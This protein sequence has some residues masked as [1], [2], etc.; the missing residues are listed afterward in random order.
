MS[1]LVN[2]IP[3]MTS[4]TAPSGVARAS[5][6]Y[7]SNYPAWKA[8]DKESTSE[9]ASAWLTP[10]GTTTG[11]LEYEFDESQVVNSYGIFP[12]ENYERTHA[13][14]TWTFEGSNNGVDYD[15]LD[16]RSNE[17]DWVFKERKK[18]DFDN[19][20]PYK[21]YRINITKNDGYA[22]YTAIQ[23]LEMFF[24]D[25]NTNKILLLSEGGNVSKIE[26]GYGENIFP[27]MTS[28]ITPSGTI[29][30]SSVYG[31]N[32]E[33]WRAFDG[34]QE[35]SW[36]SRG[37]T[38]HISYEFKKSKIK[39]IKLSRVSS[40]ITSAYIV[41][42]QPKDFN[43]Q[44]K[45]EGS[46]ATVIEVRGETDWTNIEK[47]YELG[48]QEEAEGIRL[49][50]IANNGH[51]GYTGFSKIEAYSLE[52][53]IVNIPSQSEQS[54]ITYGMSPQEL[55]V[56]FST[57]STK[58]HYI[59]D[60]STPLGEGKVFE[61]VLDVSKVLKK[62]SIAP[63]TTDKILILNDGSCKK[64]DGSWQ[65]V[66]T[67][68]PTE[69]D[70]ID[71]GMEASNIGAIP[72]TAWAELQALG[73]IKI[74]YYT[75]SPSTEE[76]TIKTETEPYTIYDE[77]GN[78][79]EVLYYTDDPEVFSANIQTTHELNLLQDDL[80][81]A[82]KIQILNWFE[83]EENVNLQVFGELNNKFTSINK[84]INHEQVLKIVADSIGNAKFLVSEDK[85]T[86]K[87]WNTVEW[88]TV[89]FSHKDE[90]ATLGMSKNALK[91]ITKAQWEQLGHEFY[92]GV[93]L[94][95][96]TEIKNINYQSGIPNLTPEISNASLYILNTTATLDITL[97]GNKLYG[98][99]TD[100]DKGKVQYRIILNGD[101]YLPDDGTF[102]PL[103]PEPQNIN[104]RIP[105]DK[106][107]IGGN[108]TIRI[109]FQD[110]WGSLDYWQTSFIGELNG[111]LFF[112]EQGELYS[113]ELGEVIKPL[114]FGTIITGQ[115]SL[116]HKI[117]FKNTLG[118]PVK[119]V[120][121]FSD[122]GEYNPVAGVGYRFS[123]SDSPFAGYEVL[124]LE[125]PVDHEEEVEI[126]VKM[127][128]ILGTTPET[129]GK[130][131]FCVKA[132]EID[133]DEYQEILNNLS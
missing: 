60:E 44:V 13:P 115:M 122:W 36:L 4:N 80:L 19:S 112:D 50:V 46:W 97:Q 54:F 87:K 17:T 8:F 12:R 125:R 131:K 129:L 31:S 100:D 35:T 114:D 70:Y 126:F 101:P 83:E 52:N 42:C 53:T 30:T 45:K 92:L 11:W 76:I 66:T 68:T 121:F 93:Y 10:S 29:N 56:D 102:T 103:E 71:N 95:K 108:N 40:S 132:T 130:V 32:F 3:K 110:A 43:I 55:S 2:L 38:G 117:I 107:N 78:T 89:T 94:D 105:S 33:G 27:I 65:I 24:E 86:W 72:E 51:S 41:T 127:S 116:E 90:I 9:A 123:L 118:Q 77:F 120:K 28:N 21:M 98:A 34:S 6:I 91:D 20:V 39:R 23:E 124:E 133:D 69:Q 47:E 15:V 49:E 119:D 37:S 7:G 79:M 106:I 64:W 22:T 58:K 99:V 88:E 74:L 26:H 128:T 48:L 59:Q 62:V 113:D 18:Y 84:V 25:R 73:E 57:E 85:I 63:P 82:D 104:L 1:E 14:N 81:Q 109:E 96:Q 61:Q 111:L 5:A 75:D 67:S 16:S